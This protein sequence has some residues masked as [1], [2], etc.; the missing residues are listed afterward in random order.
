M[1]V[2]EVDFSAPNIILLVALAVLRMSLEVVLAAQ[3]RGVRQQN[4]IE[5]IQAVSAVVHTVISIM[6]PQ[7]KVCI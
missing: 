4:P 3:V 1:G 7:N 2:I 5:L 6:L